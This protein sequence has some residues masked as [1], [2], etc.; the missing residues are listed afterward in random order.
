ME[1][2]E[3]DQWEEVWKTIDSWTEEERQDFYEALGC[4]AINGMDYLE[5]EGD[6]DGC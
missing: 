3:K 1:E 4:M 2:Q 6:C 5:R